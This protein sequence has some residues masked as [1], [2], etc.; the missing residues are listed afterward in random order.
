MHKHG[1]APAHRREVLAEQCW[2][3]HSAAPQG[4][5]MSADI[6]RDAGSTGQGAQHRLSLTSNRERA[7]SGPSLAG[8]SISVTQ[9]RDAHVQATSKPHPQ[10]KPCRQGQ[11]QCRGGCGCSHQDAGVATPSQWSNCSW[12][13]SPSTAHSCSC[14]GWLAL[15]PSRGLQGRGGAGDPPHKMGSLSQ[16]PCGMEQPS[17]PCLSSPCLVLPKDPSPSPC[18]TPASTTP[19][20]TPGVGWAADTPSPASPY[21]VC[22]SQPLSH[23]SL[24]W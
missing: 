15:C 8:D 12:P 10:G 14:P 13:L 21:P 18:P 2:Q 11:L 9:L 23:K 7:Q 5:R 4:C 6:P 16:L 1:H 20:P 3:G 17:P 24:P 19:S 22:S